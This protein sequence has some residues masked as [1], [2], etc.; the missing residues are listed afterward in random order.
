MLKRICMIAAF[1]MALLIMFACGS[2]PTI[3]K[4]DCSRI[5]VIQLPGVNV[6][7][8]EYVTTMNIYAYNSSI[9]TANQQMNAEKIEKARCSIMCTNEKAQNELACS[10]NYFTVDKNIILQ[11]VKIRTGIIDIGHPT[12]FYNRKWLIQ[13]LYAVRNHQN[14]TTL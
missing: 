4:V 7:N 10:Q 8:L 11:N 5:E 3:A 9:I 2:P 1:S 14:K 6:V 13:N 12:L